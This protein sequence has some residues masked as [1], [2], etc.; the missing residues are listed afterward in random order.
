MK[1]PGMTALYRD[2]SNLVRSRRQIGLA[3][4]TSRGPG[5]MLLS[6]SGN[7][8]YLVNPGGAPVWL[9]GD[10]GWLAIVQLT[11]AQIDTYLTDRASRGFNLT[12][13]ELIEHYFADN[14][15][16]NIDNAAPFTS[17]LFTTPNNTYM[18]RVDYLMTKAASLGIYVMLS[19]LYQG[20]AGTEEG[21]DTEI[22][23]ASTS[24]MQT[25]GEYCGQRWGEYNNLIWCI[26]GDGAPGS[27]L[28]KYSS[29][30]TGLRNYDTR[31]LITFHDAPESLG[32]DNLSG[33]SWLTLNSSYSRTDAVS[34]YALDGYA[35]SPTTPCIQIEGRYEYLSGTTAQT[36]R[37]Q[38]YW[39]VLCG[40][41]G[42]IYGSERVWQLG[43][44]SNDWET[45]MG[46]T[47]AQHMTIG[48]AWIRSKAWY[49]LVPDSGHTTL[50]AGYGTLGNANYAACARVADGSLVAIYMPSN[51][52]M[53]VDMTKL[54]GTVTARWF[55]P[56]NSSYTADAASP[57]ANTGTHDF[58]RSATNSAGAA[59]WV[60]VLEA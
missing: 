54:S 6:A 24:D 17:T 42:H 27:L 25:W 56:T 11:N 53:T 33:A 7:S 29:F 55:D 45:E 37:A 44:D 40:Q 50:T 32:S 8:R 34:S 19:P 39:S 12:V 9:M 51:R 35:A 58:S 41:C 38:L 21:W 30:A 23:A 2:N 26:G 20:Y 22:A 18:N 10:A 57:L 3:V 59:D 15:P 5:G 31:H 43:A 47:G 28:T 46:S 60:L 52:T 13:V 16:N 1:P 48:A 49:N 36:M 14:A 4:K